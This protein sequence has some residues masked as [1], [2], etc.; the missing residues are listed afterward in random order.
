MNIDPFGGEPT[1]VWE[2]MIRFMGIIPNYMKSPSE[3]RR[4]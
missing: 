3:R 4:L 1:L 2:K